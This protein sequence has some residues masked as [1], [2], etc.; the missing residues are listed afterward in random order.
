M[1]AVIAAAA[2]GPEV[3]E[4]VDR[5]TPV[6]G[7]GEVLV[8]VKATALNRA[9]LLQRMGKYPPPP[10]ATDILGLEMAGEVVEVGSGVPAAGAGVGSG[11]GL[12]P[13]DR[14]CALLPGGGYAQYVTIPAG[15]AM[16]IPEN[17]SWEEAAG[18]PEAF[19]TAYLN[20]V[21]LGGITPGL[22][23]LVHAAGSGVG[24]AALQLIR[25]MN[26]VPYATA[27]TPEKLNKSMELGAAAVWNYRDGSFL[28]WLKQQTAGEG[29]Q[30]VLDFVGAPYVNDHLSA[31]AVD[32]KLIVI[33]TLGGSTVDG[34][35]LGL[36]LGKRLQII[37]TALRSRS[38]KDKI[39]LSAEFADF[40]MPR[41]AD[42]RMKPIID[43][44]FELEAVTDAHRYME[45]N[46]N[47]GKIVVRLP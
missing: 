18:I 11:A 43:S 20:L 14:V 4:I 5:P 2:G 45:S 28:P 36:L 7:E 32:G 35:N 38:V 27:G 39:R 23:I 37:G 33:G 3:L 6:P 44:V 22:R 46:A 15:M 13:G 8:R 21:W 16:G 29:V 24:T 47:I 25:E 1:K 42:G 17:L 34:F 41:F 30:L 19:L 10:G 31:L 40:A 9:D 12:R 26:A